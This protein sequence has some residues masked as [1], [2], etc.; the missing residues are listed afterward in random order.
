M[1]LFY[2]YG[3]ESKAFRFYGGAPVSLS[4][5]APRKREPS[6][7]PKK[8]AASARA[9]PKP[10]KRAQK[11][12][13]EP[14]KR[15][16]SPE[17]RKRS[18]PKKRKASP[19]KKRRSPSPKT[20][21]KAES[22]SYASSRSPSRPPKKKV[23]ARSVSPKGRETKGKKDRENGEKAKPQARSFLGALAA[24]KANQKDMPKPSEDDKWDKDS[25]RKTPWDPSLMCG[26][27]ECDFKVCSDR[28]VSEFFCC[29]KCLISNQ[30]PLLAIIS[31][32]RNRLDA[33]ECSAAFYCKPIGKPEHGK[34]CE[35]EKAQKEEKATPP[36]DPKSGLPGVGA[37]HVCHATKVRKAKFFLAF[38]RAPGGWTKN[39]GNRWGMYGNGK[40]YGKAWSSWK[41]TPK[42]ESKEQT[43][44]L[45]AWSD[46]DE[47][48]VP[49]TNAAIKKA[50]TD[51]KEEATKET[52]Q[53][54]SAD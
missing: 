40:S 45:R 52:L 46:D 22:S 10:K 35:Q 2:S 7:K 18:P 1:N 28:S 26:H 39:S 41:E 30:L 32:S 17:P 31:G 48:P 12:S 29:G 14:K 3:A 50:K 53:F 54:S 27:P 43:Q 34:R 47:P 19:P 37:T 23:A 49:R 6:P 42:E 11:A 24:V 9:S 25:K 13:P 33:T 5:L 20:R 36:E 51:E 15:K 44:G 4:S 16:A 38:H 8:R 21:R